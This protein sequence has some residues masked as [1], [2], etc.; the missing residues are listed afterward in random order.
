MPLH[1]FIL[2]FPLFVEQ[3][4]LS[5]SL[6]LK[7]DDIIPAASKPVQK[8]PSWGSFPGRCQ[9]EPG[10]CKLVSQENHKPFALQNASYQ[11]NRNREKNVF[12]MT[13]Y[14]LNAAAPI[15]DLDKVHTEI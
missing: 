3:L 1:P 9:L 5:L 15:A 2:L 7:E 10:I 4:S 12:Q 14:D 11:G 8:L 13:K 6:P